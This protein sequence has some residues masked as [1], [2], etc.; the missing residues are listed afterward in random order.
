MYRN[1]ILRDE[2]TRKEGSKRYLT[3]MYRTIKYVEGA[4]AQSS[5]YTPCMF[6]IDDV[7]FESLREL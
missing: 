6:V 2:T 5:S 3:D 7:M 1:A 4:R